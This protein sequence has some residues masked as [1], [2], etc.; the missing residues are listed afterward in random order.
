[1]LMAVGHIANSSAALYDGTQWH[2]YLLSASPDA[3]SYGYIDRVFTSAPWNATPSTIKHY[4]SLPAVV[5][6][7]LAISLGIIFVLMAISFVYL[8]FKHKRAP[9]QYYNDPM[10]EW[11]PKYRPTSLL[12]MLNAANLTDPAAVAPAVASSSHPNNDATAYSTALDPGNAT[13]RGQ[14]SMDMTDRL[15]DSSG[16]SMTGVTFAALLARATE[17]AASDDSPTLYYAK[18]PFEAK[19]FGELAFEA[20]TAVVVTDTSDNVWWMGYKDDGHGNA[21]SGL[22]PSNY[23]TKT[24]PT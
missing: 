1:M 16:L 2:P 11:K 17:G 22:F 12:A 5:L 21:I 19:E 4:L 23:V 20:Q 7:S 13:H 6:I 14:A 24:K 8:Y 10:N 15:R 3:S 18:Y 9:V